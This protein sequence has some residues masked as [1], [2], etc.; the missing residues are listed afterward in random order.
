MPVEILVNL[1]L[2]SVEDAFDK[3]FMMSNNIDLIINC[4]LEEDYPSHRRHIRFPLTSHFTDDSKE[5][6]EFFLQNIMEVCGHI[7]TTLS[8]NKG[9]LIYCYDG[10]QAGPAV[11]TAYIMLTG[12]LN[13]YTA[14][15]AIKTKAPWVLEPYISYKYALRSLE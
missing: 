12:R 3:E 14:I 5:A 10:I 11:L 8:E 7:K 2:G 4:S 9:I 13:S 15:Q 6:N 1:W